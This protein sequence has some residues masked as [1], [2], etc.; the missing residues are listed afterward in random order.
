M[1]VEPAWRWN[2]KASRWE[3]WAAELQTWVFDH[4]PLPQWYIDAEGT[5]PH[6][7]FLRLWKSATDWS[8]LHQSIFWL[9][10]EEV[11]SIAEQLTLECR[12]Y[13]V[14]SPANL[15][16]RGVDPAPSMNVT[17]LL[18]SGLVT[19]IEGCEISIM[20]EEPGYNPMEALFEA[21]KNR[22]SQADGPRPF[23]QAVEQGKFTAKH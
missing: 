15:L 8:E 3:Q 1:S 16:M 13:G 21:Q 23:F 5:I 19:Q 11:Q 2:S 20:T 17:E 7:I 14:E 9:S 6:T 12:K 22:A 4:K 10:L 18:E